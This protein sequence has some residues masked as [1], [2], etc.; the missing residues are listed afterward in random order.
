MTHR[1]SE[2]SSTETLVAANH[3]TVNGLDVEKLGRQRPDVFSSTWVEV[4]FV[5]SIL[6]AL[7]MAVWTFRA[8][9]DNDVH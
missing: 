2:S 7:S 1:T 9:D 5:A 4:A 6:I 3:Q 8:H